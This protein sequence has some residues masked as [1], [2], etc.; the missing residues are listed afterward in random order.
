MVLLGLGSS[1]NFAE[2]KER[3]WWLWHFLSSKMIK[4][5]ES[6][7]KVC[8]SGFWFSEEKGCRG[9]AALVMGK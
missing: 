4:Q 2:E 7:H 3:G 1:W 5:K 8:L 9:L 6:L